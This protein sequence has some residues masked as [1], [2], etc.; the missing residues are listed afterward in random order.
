[1]NA[2]EPGESHQKI[3]FI[4]YELNEVIMKTTSTLIFRCNRN[5]RLVE[6]P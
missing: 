6:E 1:M 2:T 3:Y 4:I 5:G